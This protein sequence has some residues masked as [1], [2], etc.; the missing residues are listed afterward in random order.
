[1]LT[2]ERRS[3]HFDHRSL[4]FGKLRNRLSK[5]LLSGRLNE[6]VASTGSATDLMPQ[7]TLSITSKV[8]VVCVVRG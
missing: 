7:H 5:G 8:R 3:L 2:K 4:P 1:M 6:K